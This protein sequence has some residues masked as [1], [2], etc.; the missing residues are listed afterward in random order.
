MANYEFHYEED[1]EPLQTWIQE[2]VY[3]TQRLNRTKAQTG[4]LEAF[5]GLEPREVD[6]EPTLFSIYSRDV[7]ASVYFRLNSST[8]EIRV[9]YESEEFGNKGGNPWWCLAEPRN[10]ESTVCGERPGKISMLPRSDP[11]GLS[12][13]EHLQA[14][15]LR[16]IPGRGNAPRANA[17]PRPRNNAWTNV[18]QNAGSRKKSGKRRSTRKMKK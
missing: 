8:G 15:V 10:A 13:L 5:G 17:V 18:P 1:G 4:R 12:I 9:S 2:K 3:A 16:R 7:E 6:M 11:H 14:N